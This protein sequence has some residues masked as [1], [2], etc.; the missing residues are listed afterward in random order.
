VAILSTVLIGIGSTQAAGGTTH[1]NMR[2][3]HVAFF[4]AAL[5]AV[6][7]AAIALTIHDGDAA[8]TMVRRGR[9][10]RATAPPGPVPVPVAESLA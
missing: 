2:A 5:F 4:A 10:V 6:A 7:A 1:A 9:R 3:Y 8:E